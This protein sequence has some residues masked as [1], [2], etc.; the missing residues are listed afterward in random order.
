[1]K[2]PDLAQK[3][4]VED[5]RTGEVELRDAIWVRTGGLQRE[6]YEEIR[7]S[8]GFTKEFVTDKVTAA[9]VNAMTKRASNFAAGLNHT[10]KLQL[11]LKFG[12]P[13]PGVHFFC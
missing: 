4:P 2:D 7:K 13:D 10:L 8:K 12:L 6:N 11:V 1:M 5:K 3:M 9:N